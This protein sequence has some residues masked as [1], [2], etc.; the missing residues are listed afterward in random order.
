MTVLADKSPFVCRIATLDGVPSQRM[1]AEGTAQSGA[2]RMHQ[3]R[4]RICMLV[5]IAPL[6]GGPG[7]HESVCCHRGVGDGD[8]LEVQGRTGVRLR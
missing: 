5:M 6:E 3:S 4:I 2:M 7:V 1:F 8:G